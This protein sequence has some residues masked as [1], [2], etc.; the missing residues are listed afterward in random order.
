LNIRTIHYFLF[1]TAVEYWIGYNPSRYEANISCHKTIP[2]IS[3]IVG[4]YEWDQFVY[5]LKKIKEIAEKHGKKF[6]VKSCYRF[7]QLPCSLRRFFK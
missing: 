6:S 1:L 3:T 7:M 5:K 4:D 2:H